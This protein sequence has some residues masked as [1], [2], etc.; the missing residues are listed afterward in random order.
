MVSPTFASFDTFAGVDRA[1]A[2]AK[3]AAQV[4]EYRERLVE[5]YTKHNPSNVARVD[6][7]LA[8]YREQEKFLF[9][10]VCAKYGEVVDKAHAAANG[11]AVAGVGITSAPLMAGVSPMPSSAI[12]GTTDSISAKASSEAS[13]AEQVGPGLSPVADSCVGQVSRPKAVL[14]RPVSLPPPR[15]A[16]AASAPA[17]PLALVA[18]ARQVNG[19]G[20]V[21]TPSTAA[22]ARVQLGIAQ[23]RSREPLAVTSKASP[24]KS[25]HS[26]VVDDQAVPISFNDTHNSGQPPDKTEEELRGHVEELQGRLAGTKTNIA[27]HDDLS[28][29]ERDKLLCEI[30][31][32]L[33]DQAT[34]FFDEPMV[35]SDSESDGGSESSEVSEASMSSPG[36][37]TEVE[38]KTSGATS[39]QV[40]RQAKAP[41]KDASRVEVST[42][43]NAGAPPAAKAKSRAPTRPLAPP[44]AEAPMHR[45]TSRGHHEA[46]SSSNVHVAI[47]P[48][49]SARSTP[50]AEGPGPL[51]KED[52]EDDDSDIDD[53]MLAGKLGAML[54][55]SGESKAPPRHAPPPLVI[56]AGKASIPSKARAPTITQ[57]L[58]RAEGS[59]RAKP[60]W[61][62]PPP[63]RGAPPP[64]RQGAQGKAGPL[65]G[66]MPPPPNG[67]VARPKVSAIAK[68]EKPAPELFDQWLAC[69][70]FVTGWNDQSSYTTDEIR[71]SLRD[72]LA[73]EGIDHALSIAH[74]T[75]TVVPLL[76]DLRRIDAAVV[77]NLKVEVLRSLKVVQVSILRIVTY[78]LVREMDARE[79]VKL[80]RRQ[81]KLNGKKNCTAE[82][83]RL[84]SNKKVYL[85][86]DIGSLA[87]VVRHFRFDR[88][89]SQGLHS[90]ILSIRRQKHNT[91]KA[92]TALPALKRRR[93]GSA[94]AGQEDGPAEDDV[95]A[96]PRKRV[97]AAQ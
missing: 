11:A 6:V 9:H 1:T 58:V 43:R 8:R 15:P 10:S 44:L 49:V 80:Q 75:A 73:E 17:Q 4:A 27:R 34:G 35:S 86:A 33:H 83:A 63:L 79:E 93:P 68:E 88:S 54:Q 5:I 29:E 18:V 47:E 53:S 30:D 3:A 48:V 87:Q 60:A 19:S 39:S 2:E 67:A 12:S 94:A 74:L 55:G 7:L 56:A 25:A 24:A 81:N 71:D 14:P 51:A 69:L 59:A 97:R 28:P 57:G 42:A 82:P 22:A 78:E 16:Q 23:A 52:L 76:L 89:F 45:A 32:I 36:E 50:S 40:S 95:G 65:V 38:S 66:G 21:A 41:P 70:K 91:E 13:V 61:G 90:L 64:L 96:R 46:R 77:K 37:P 85:A 62:A 31:F 26:V 84:G 92:A 20:V 72:H